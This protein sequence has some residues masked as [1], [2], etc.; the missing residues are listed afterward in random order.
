MP[1][2]QEILYLSLY[3]I[4]LQSAVLVRTYLFDSGTINHQLSTI[5][6]Q[7]STPKQHHYAFEISTQ[8][9]YK[10]PYGQLKLPSLNPNFPNY[11]YKH[12]KL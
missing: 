10:S 5:N 12:Q 1:I 8:L 6:Y 7:P 11:P 2:P 9:L 4:D 3:L